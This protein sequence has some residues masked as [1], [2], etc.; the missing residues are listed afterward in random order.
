MLIK[1]WQWWS[2]VSLDP[3]NDILLAVTAVILLLTLLVIIYQLHQSLKI[4]RMQYGV[5]IMQELRTE[6]W[7]EIFKN[8]YQAK[9]D[10]IND[11]R[12]YLPEV[13]YALD[14]FEW[15]GTML[16]EHIFYTDLVMKLIGGLPIRV[17]YKLDEVGFVKKRRKERGHYAI[18]AEDFTKKSIE[19]QIKNMPME[20]WTKL[21]NKDILT[22]LVKKKLISSKELWWLNLTRKK[23]S[24]RNRKLNYGY[25][26]KSSK[27]LEEA[28]Q[29]NDNKTIY[30][31]FLESMMESNIT[32]EYI[33]D[34]SK[35]CDHELNLMLR[36]NYSISELRNNKLIL[37]SHNYCR[38]IELRKNKW[39]VIVGK[40]DY[41]IVKSGDKMYNF[42][43]YEIWYRDIFK[44]IK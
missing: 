12:K 25:P 29:N 10:E 21:D 33:L 9:N 5:L 41:T 30:K 27:K 18:F 40:R 17:W 38:I 11:E 19:Y 31:F 22:E 37:E 4:S 32:N 44:S 35:L 15:V 3:I 39:K 7:R 8:I 13:E 23:N 6:K 28:L 43:G 20:E 34:Q 42:K 2:T 1:I 16:D 36:N 24:I 26:L 14:K